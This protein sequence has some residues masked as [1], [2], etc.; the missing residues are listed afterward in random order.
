MASRTRR[1]PAPPSVVWE[2]LTDPRRSR[3]R[4]WLTLL[5]DE[6][7][8]TVVEAEK[9]YRVVWSSL[10]PDRPDDQV[11]IELAA[12]GPETSLRFILLTPHQ[13]PDDTDVRSRR[14]R[15]SE[16]LFA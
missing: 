14:R 15:V 13:G 11:H 12:A 10:W 1:Q 6:L 9:P 8:P 16:L 7:E 5:P 4:P 2:S 3:T